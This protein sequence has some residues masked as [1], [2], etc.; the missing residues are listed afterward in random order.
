MEEVIVVIFQVFFEL[1]IQFFGSPGISWA[2]GSDKFDKGCGYL[3]LHAVAGGGIG[4]ISTLIAPQLVLPFFWLRLCNLVFTPLAS[5]GIS[6]GFATW[7]KAR[8]SNWDPLTH[9]Y[10]GALFAFM[11]GAARFAFGTH[12]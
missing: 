5:G 1:T 3:F 12:P 9:F 6:Y 8:G 10:H 4:W 7:A 2:T 11:F